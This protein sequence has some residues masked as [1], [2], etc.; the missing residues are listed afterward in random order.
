MAPQPVKVEGLADLRRALRDLEKKAPR[1]LNKALRLAMEPVELVASSRTP[2]DTGRLQQ[3]NRVAVRGTRVV[4]RNTQPY[5]NTIHWGRKTLRG[6]PSVVEPRP[7][8]YQTLQEQRGAIGAL[9]IREVE[10]FIEREIP[11]S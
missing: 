4:L 7:W 9:V 8:L 5:A 2:R 11:R 6:S 1:E 10:R 3:S